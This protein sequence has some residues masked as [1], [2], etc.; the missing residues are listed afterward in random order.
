MRWLDGITKPG[1]LQSMGSQRVGH[2][3][4]TELNSTGSYIWPKGYK[5]IL[6]NVLTEKD[7]LSFPF[8]HF[9]MGNVDMIAGALA[10][11][12]NNEDESL[13]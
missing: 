4:V 5:Y 1:T 9:V 8:L 11:T 2:D 3:W 6:G 12:L 13:T 7:W 10:A